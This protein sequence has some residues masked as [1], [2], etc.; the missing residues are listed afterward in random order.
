MIK[1]LHIIITL[2][3]TD[4]MGATSSFEAQVRVNPLAVKVRLTPRVIKPGRGP[5]WVRAILCLAR[6][7]DA[8]KIDPGS[9]C[10]VEN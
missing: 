9:V 2:T 3:V 8:S 7:Y 4:N 6:G 10:I 1:I 5:K